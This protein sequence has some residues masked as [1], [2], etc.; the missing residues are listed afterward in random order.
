MNQGLLGNFI[1]VILIFQ[2]SKFSYLQMVRIFKQLNRSI[3]MQ[4]SLYPTNRLG[5]ELKVSHNL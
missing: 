3:N 4:V 1:L 2:F 5:A